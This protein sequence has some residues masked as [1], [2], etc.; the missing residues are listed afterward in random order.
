MARLRDLLSTHNG[1][2]QYNIWYSALNKRDQEFA[3][4]LVDCPGV[5]VHPYTESGD[6]HNLIV[7]LAYTG[8]LRA[9]LPPFVRSF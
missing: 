5:T 3:D 6:D 1:V 7:H 2:T 4:R 8:T 9:I